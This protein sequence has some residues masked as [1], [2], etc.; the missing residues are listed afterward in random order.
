MGCDLEKENRGI[1]SLWCVLGGHTENWCLNELSHW[2]LQPWIEWRIRHLPCRRHGKIFFSIPLSSHLSL[3]LP[4]QNLDHMRH[5]QLPDQLCN[6]MM[7]HQCQ[8]KP[9][10]S[11]ENLPLE[12]LSTAGIS[13]R[14]LYQDKLRD[15]RNSYHQIKTSTRPPVGIVSYSL[16][17]S[18]ELNEVGNMLSLDRA[19]SAIPILRAAKLKSEASRIQRL[20]KRTIQ[21]IHT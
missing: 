12:I 15:D 21:L 17:H 19:E 2:Q 4:C 13:I 16:L 3:C 11:F 18:C 8:G 7:L 6:V 9:R 1:K 14:L 20:S 10:L 5:P